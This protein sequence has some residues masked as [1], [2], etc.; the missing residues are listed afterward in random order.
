MRL[1]LLCAAIV[2]PR[3][4]LN[5][6][7]VTGSLTPLSA[8]LCSAIARSLAVFCCHLAILCARVVVLTALRL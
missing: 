3:L 5:A 1:G 7:L 2:L 6:A 4:S 8:G